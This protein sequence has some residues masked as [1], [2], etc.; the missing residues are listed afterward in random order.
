MWHGSIFDMTCH[1]SIC[2]MT[3]WHDCVTWLIPIRNVTHI[4]RIT[5]L[6][7]TWPIHV[8]YMTPSHLWRGSY[9][10]CHDFIFDMTLQLKWLHIWHDTPWLYMWQECVTWLMHDTPWLQ[11]DMNVWYDSFMTHHDSTCDMTHSYLW[12]GP[13]ITRHDSIRDMTLHLT[14][15]I[16]V[17]EMTRSH[18]WRD[19]YITRHDSTCDMPHSY[20]WCGPYIT[21]HD[22]IRDSY[23]TRHDSICDMPL[24]LTESGPW[25]WGSSYRG[26]KC[27]IHLHHTEN[28]AKIYRGGGAR[29]SRLL[30][31]NPA[32]KIEDSRFQVFTGVPITYKFS[33]FHWSPHNLQVFTGVPKFSYRFS[34]K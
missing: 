30:A 27:E 12:C 11:S 23:I 28:R 1:D 18:L 25:E 17:C 10:M 24:Y 16:H 34:Q 5:T 21:R 3:V 13:Y 22:S 20:L 8:C 14:W 2:D 29:D 33:S 19:S 15:L 32:R 4:S 6:Y 7:V 9:M 26:G 31:W